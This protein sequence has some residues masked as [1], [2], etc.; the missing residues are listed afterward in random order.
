[1]TSN[2]NT[3]QSDLVIIGVYL[4]IHQ[5]VRMLMII[6]FFRHKLFIYS[7]LMVYRLRVL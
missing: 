7:S 6:T 3:D 1:M 2:L 5:T 4:S